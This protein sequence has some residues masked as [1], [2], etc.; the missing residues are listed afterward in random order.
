IWDPIGSLGI[1]RRTHMWNLPTWETGLETHMPRAECVRQLRREF[2]LFWAY[3]VPADVALRLKRGFKVDEAARMVP[4]VIAAHRREMEN[5]RL[6][7]QADAAARAGAV[8]P[9]TYTVSL[10]EH[11]TLDVSSHPTRGVRT[12]GSP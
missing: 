7:K 9:G 8:E 3:R 5:R 6:V 10:P 2:G 11:T 12:P 1:T 4:E